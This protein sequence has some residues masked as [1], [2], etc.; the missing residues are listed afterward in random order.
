MTNEDYVFETF[1]SESVST[2]ERRIVLL[3]SGKYRLQWK[4]SDDLWLNYIFK[5]G[6]NYTEHYVTANRHAIKF[7]ESQN[8]D[9]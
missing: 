2:P 8:A 7:Q 9:L 4:Y 1:K 5:G 3:A 6:K